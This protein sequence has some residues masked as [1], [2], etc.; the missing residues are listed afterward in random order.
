MLTDHMGVF[1]YAVWA[2][3]EKD[4]LLHFISRLLGSNND[5]SNIKSISTVL[6]ITTWNLRT[7]TSV[8]FHPL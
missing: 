6:A 8:V 4:A 3:A 2:K 5:I 1:I 7:K